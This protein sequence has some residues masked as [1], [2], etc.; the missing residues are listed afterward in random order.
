MS[1]CIF[2]Q[3]L[4]GRFIILGNRNLSAGESPLF[5]SI[6]MITIP[7]HS[8][9]CLLQLSLPADILFLTIQ[10]TI[11]L[12][13]PSLFVKTRLLNRSDFFGSLT[14]LYFLWLNNKKL[15]ILFIKENPNES[16][17]T[18]YSIWRSFPHR[19]RQTSRHSN[20][21]QEY[22]R[23]RY[24]KYAENIHLSTLFPQK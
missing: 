5:W 15:Y 21:K 2:I 6:H 4:Q 16:K 24:G 18:K 19:L 3:R 14:L 23:P 7:L 17:F 12:S 9:F 11:I 22:R 13:N 10:L 8:Q 1:R 20:P